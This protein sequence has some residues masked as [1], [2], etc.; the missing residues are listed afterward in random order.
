M[1]DVLAEV[2]EGIAGRL[3]IVDSPEGIQDAV[4]ELLALAEGQRTLASGPTAYE[5]R[6]AAGDAYDAIEDY[7]GWIDDEQ[8]AR[9]HVGSLAASPPYALQWLERRA[10]ERIERIP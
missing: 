2:L 4:N 1:S 9:A 7:T 3:S 8:L 6:T 10:P 5:Y